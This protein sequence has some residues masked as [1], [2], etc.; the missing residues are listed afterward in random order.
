MKIIYRPQVWLAAL[1]VATVFL[2]MARADDQT[3]PGVGNAAA[4]TLAAGSPLVRSALV[5]LQQQLL[6]MHNRSLRDATFDALFNPRTC[7]SIALGWPRR[8]SRQ[9]CRR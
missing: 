6:L 9:P 5:R 7:C 4:S 3:M 2:P 8:R 1:L